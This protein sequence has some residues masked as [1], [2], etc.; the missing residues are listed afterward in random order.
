METNPNAA[1]KMK[2]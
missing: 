1:D 2:I